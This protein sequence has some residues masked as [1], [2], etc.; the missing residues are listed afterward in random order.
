MSAN[1]QTEGPEWDNGCD[2]EWYALIDPD[3]WRCDKCEVEVY[4]YIYQTQIV[5]VV[6]P[7]S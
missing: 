5:K 7:W 3:Y 2:H 6:L 1:P 4:N